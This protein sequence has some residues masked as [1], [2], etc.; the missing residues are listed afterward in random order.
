[1]HCTKNLSENLLKTAF[2]DKDTAAVR[3]DMQARGICPHLHL[4][5]VG[6]N[7]DKLRMPDAPY[8]L[9]TED[10]L[11]VLGVL[12]NLRTPTH[13][14]SALYSK[15]S[16]GKLS[17]LN[18]H[19]F[20]VL[21]QQI[22]PLCFRKILNKSLVAVVV[23]LSR[24]FRKLCAKIVDRLDKAQMTANSV[25]IMCLMEMEMPPS[26]FDIISHLPNHLVEELFICGPVHTRWMYPY[27]CYFKTLKGYVRN[28]AKPEGSIAQGYQ[29]E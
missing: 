4:Q 1:M 21:L 15:I 12:Q 16:Q 5:A 3:V 14:V 8:V 13:Y 2:D 18:S 27:E 10:K 6:P 25:E 7:R 24:P 29:I 20:H 11:K 22:L 19:D 17:G 23:K 26:F 28:Y 9:T